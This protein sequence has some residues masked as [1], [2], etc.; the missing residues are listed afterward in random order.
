VVYQ[1]EGSKKGTWYHRIKREV[2]TGYYSKSLKTT[3]RSLA[4]SKAFEEYKML[5]VAEASSAQYGYTG[6]VSLFEKF[7]KGNEWSLSRKRTILKTYNTYLKPFFAGYQIHNINNIVFTQWLHWRLTYWQSK[8][9]NGEKMPVHYKLNPAKSSVSLERSVLVQFLSWCA[10]WQYLR[11]VPIL[12]TIDK[13]NK[14]VRRYCTFKKKNRAMSMSRGNE[15]KSRLR[16]YAFETNG[17]GK[18]NDKRHR[19]TRMR[20]YFFIMIS[21]HTVLRPTT[22]LTRMSWSNVKMKQ[23]KRYPDLYFAYIKHQW[24]K[25]QA[26]NDNRERTAVSTYEGARIITEWRKI[27][28]EE[29]GLG[30]DS[31][32]VFPNLD[33]SVVDTRRLGILFRSLLIKWCLR[34]EDGYDI[35]MYSFRHTK[36]RQLIIDGKKMGAVAEQSNSSLR[37]IS[38]TYFS[39]LFE[40]GDLDRYANQ[41]KGEALWD[42]DKWEGV[43]GDIER[44]G[45]KVELNKAN[46]R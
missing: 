39:P 35:T 9:D 19:Y 40:D 25:E 16:K 43:S 15:I 42:D 12:D 6:F 36:I 34:N 17:K 5:L 37:T 41:F 32:L 1:I 44:L 31:D 18:G 38:E 11:S 21:Y 20:L 2:G 28:Q 26:N 8:L 24:G 29:F 4:I 3:D 23:S 27:Q 13:K 45:F 10:K 46:K 14:L 30:K 22:E 33:G 7:I